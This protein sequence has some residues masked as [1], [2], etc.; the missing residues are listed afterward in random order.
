MILP[1]AAL[2]A[3]GAIRAGT[4]GEWV[5]KKRAVSGKSFCHVVS[6]KHIGQSS[7]A[8]T[9]GNQKCSGQIPPLSRRPTT[10]GEINWL[11]I[12]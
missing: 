6:I 7:A 2:A 9:L 4:F 11:D 5:R 8:I 3:A 12:L 10:R 1:T